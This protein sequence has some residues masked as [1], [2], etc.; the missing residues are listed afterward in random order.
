MLTLSNS[1]SALQQIIN[2]NPLRHSPSTSN[3]E[4]EIV[5]NRVPIT[6]RSRKVVE[7]DTDDDYTKSNNL[8]EGRDLPHLT[9]YVPLSLAV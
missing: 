9:L 1:L 2:S 3:D 8:D 4:I 7:S 5:A 6:G